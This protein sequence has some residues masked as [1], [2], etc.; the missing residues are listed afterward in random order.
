MN[1]TNDATY[2]GSPSVQLRVAKESGRRMMEDVEEF[3]HDVRKA[4]ANDMS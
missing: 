3:W 2:D 1:W 4:P